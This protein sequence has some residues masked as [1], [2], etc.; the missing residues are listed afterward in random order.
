MSPPPVASYEAKIRLF[1][2][3][4][5][6]CNAIWSLAPTMIRPR[7]MKVAFEPG[8]RA[9]DVGGEKMMSVLPQ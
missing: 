7:V 6:G 9:I 4:V 2:A 1:G 5:A 8:Q 3:P